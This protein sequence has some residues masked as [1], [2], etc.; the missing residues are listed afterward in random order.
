[1][2]KSVVKGSVAAAAD[3][4][5]SSHQQQIGEVSAAATST[6]NKQDQIEVSTSLGAVAN[7]V[8]P[9]DDA[10]IQLFDA[11]ASAIAEVRH[12]S[13]SS[14]RIFLIKMRIYLHIGKSC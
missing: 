2:K 7:E 10:D 14:F 13:V 5:E 1:M 11:F 12:A 3:V 4:P 8:N 6:I 9:D